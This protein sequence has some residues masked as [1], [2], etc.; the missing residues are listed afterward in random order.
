MDTAAYLTRQGWRGSGHSLHPS[1]HGI[2]KPLLVSKKN[3]LLGVGNRKSDALAGQ[4]WLKAFDNTLKQVNIGAADGAPKSVEEVTPKFQRSFYSNALYSNFVKGEGLSGTQSPA[5]KLQT[6]MG[7]IRQPDGSTN[8]GISLESKE[9]HRD[10]NRS[11][12]NAS[13]GSPLVLAI[14]GSG[15]GAL[16][17]EMTKDSQRKLEKSRKVD[18]VLAP[19]FNGEKDAAYSET[20]PLLDGVEETPWLKRKIE[21]EPW[22]TRKP[23][24]SQDKNPAAS[25]NDVLDDDPPR[26]RRRGR[27]GLGLGEAGYIETPVFGEEKGLADAKMDLS[28]YEVLKDS[29]SNPTAEEKSGK[30]K[31]QELQPIEISDDGMDILS[32]LEEQLSIGTTT[33]QEKQAQST[34]GQDQSEQLRMHQQQLKDQEIKKAKKMRKKRRKLHRAKRSLEKDPKRVSQPNTDTFSQLADDLSKDHGSASRE[35]KRMRRERRRNRILGD[36]AGQL[37]SSL[38]SMPRKKR[39]KKRMVGNNTAQPNSSSPPTPR[40]QRRETR[41]L[42]DNARQPTSSLPSTANHVSGRDKSALPKKDPKRLSV[43]PSAELVDGP[44]KTSRP[45]SGAANDMPGQG[46]P[47]PRKPRRIVGR[48]EKIFEYDD[49]LVVTPMDA[50]TQFLRN[51]AAN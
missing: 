8:E 47:A 32:K 12:H 40:K 22:E 44:A 38:P 49:E 6:K 21:H 43:R 20:R 9:E 36:D 1:G 45:L 29:R 3:N 18:H 14:A 51:R 13:E 34:N 15:S 46:K 2:A 48:N 50:I 31:G 4:W 5:T 25:R 11:A 7:S 42:G 27:K 16:E 33:G 35:Y 28:D 10:K 23:D 17:N 19:E 26:K 41:I 24:S 37:T 39:R 30:T